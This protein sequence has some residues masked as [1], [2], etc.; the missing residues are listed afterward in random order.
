MAED[1]KQKLYA[2]YLGKTSTVIDSPVAASIHEGFLKANTKV[3]RLSRYE[4]SAFDTTWI[5]VIEDILFDLGEI[6]NAPKLVTVEEGNIVPVE[7]A[8]K[9][10][11]ESVQHLAS[12]TQY[13][14]D[15]DKYNNV[16]PSKIM[17]FSNED[18][19]YTYENRF[20][21]TFV[22]RLML[23]IEKRYEFVEQY[24]PLHK[25]EAMVIRS[26]AKI[27]GAEV[28]IESKIK[29]TALSEDPEADAARRAAE[30]IET[31]RTYIMYYFGSPFMQKMKTERDVRKPILMTNILRKNPKYHRCYEAFMFVDKYDSLGMDYHSKEYFHPLSEKESDDLA[32]LL[33]H[34]YLA[35]ND[36]TDVSTFKCR[37]K[38][39]H[40]KILTSID[41]EEFVYGRI[42]SAKLEFVRVDQ[43]YQDYLE[44]KAGKILP[45]NPSR[46]IH[47]FY[48]EDYYKRFE[49]LADLKEVNKLIRRK[50]QAVSAFEAVI[51]EI[52][53]K[54][55]EEDELLRQMEEEERLSDEEAL[56]NK[57]R[58]EIERLAK[59]LT[60]DE[61][62]EVESER[63]PTSEEFVAEVPVYTGE[64]LVVTF[65]SVASAT[66]N[67]SFASAIEPEEFELDEEEEEESYEEDEDVLAEG[68]ENLAENEE[69]VAESRQNAA[70]GEESLSEE[71]SKEASEDE[72]GES[73][74]EAEESAEGAAERAAGKAGAASDETGKGAT[75]ER[76]SEEASEEPAEGSAEESSDVLASSESGSAEGVSSGAESGEEASADGSSEAK[77][78]LSGTSES[79]EAGSAAALAAG[80]AGAAAGAA[81]GATIALVE[82]EGEEGALA[83]A[84][85]AEGGEDADMEEPSSD[86]PVVSL[87]R[88]IIKIQSRGRFLRK[89][90]EFRDASYGQNKMPL[91]PKE[92]E[93]WEQA[94]KEAGLEGDD[95]SDVE[96]VFH[97]KDM[98]KAGVSTL[99]LDPSSTEIPPVVQYQE[100]KEE[101]GA[102]LSAVKEA[103]EGQE[104]TVEAPANVP[105]VSLPRKVIKVQGRGRFLRKKK[106]YRDE[107]YGQTQLPLNPMELEDLERAK[108]EA[109]LENEDVDV[110][111]VFGEIE[112]EQENVSQ[113][114]AEEIPAE[115]APIE[116]K[117]V[118]SA[119]EP[120]EEKTIEEIEK[121]AEVAP[122]DE[123]VQEEEPLIK[124]EPIEEPA[125]EPRE[126]AVEETPAEIPA[127]M[128]Q[129]DENPAEEAILE[130]PA[131][132]EQTVEE[133]NAEAIEEPKA[134]MVEEPIEQP[135]KQPEEEPVEE[136][137][138]EPEPEPAEEPKEEPAEEAKPEPEP[139]L[140]PKPVSKP[141]TKKTKSK[142][143]DN[144]DKPV[145][146][147][148]TSKDH[149]IHTTSDLNDQ[150][151]SYT[152]STATSSLGFG[153]G[154]KEGGESSGRQSFVASSNPSSFAGNSGSFIVKC[155]DGYFVSDGVFS[156]DKA[157]AYV[158]TDFDKAI[159]Q[160]RRYG[161][162]VIK[163]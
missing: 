95:N 90:K 150:S 142:S 138:P 39:V 140:E 15:V 57:K 74:K 41:D 34:Q 113:P 119:A 81:A 109:G 93:A 110:Q 125:E 126:E 55:E 92:L 143:A 159:K 79:S 133:A 144:S 157:R 101:S 141:K 106:E 148:V 102:T 22:R 18:W 59:G 147:P 17:S 108:K 89:K 60:D 38:D 87:P 32:W 54:R 97:D 75:G 85:V 53:R 96:V 6:I 72:T 4:S 65:S 84:M 122:I 24:I 130:A 36:N 49:A 73:S 25:E 131:Q 64:P 37:K 151:S 112:P 139:V 66:E 104:A 16:I 1:N 43:D 103:E 149:V 11:G 100:G 69:N 26:K 2:K 129:K 31:V 10:K 56:L 62:E 127:E 12:H 111:L 77:E 158:F 29:V 9:I 52:I 35:L 154:K 145:Y 105:V 124:D 61:E 162:K 91:N 107:D 117:P 51:E 98:E 40:P 42:P 23:F 116:E 94:K 152:F 114:A 63:R 71:A 13:I 160:K 118:K 48:A 44:R 21:A 136:A 5:S 146:K 86:T 156:K 83:G 14:K 27:D 20:I 28:E 30:R 134:E 58:A 115:T 82:G 45:R 8:K 123:P 132:E 99:I 163:L 33:Y 120:T 3:L 46:Q 7:L 128:G 135:A 70:E 47:D 50:H 153:Q 137:K 76:T 80:I 155:P 121:P 68:E 88:K 78:S 161:G 19:L 67:A